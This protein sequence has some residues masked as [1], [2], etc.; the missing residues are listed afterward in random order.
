ME[1][2]PRTYLTIYLESSLRLQEKKLLLYCINPPPVSFPII[3][4]YILCFGL[5]RAIMQLHHKLELT[6]WK[7]NQEYKNKFPVF[8]INYCGAISVSPGTRHKTA[9]R[10]S[11]WKH[12][13]LVCSS[14]PMFQSRS[15]GCWFAQGNFGNGFFCIVE[16]LYCIDETWHETDTWPFHT[17]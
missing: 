16:N 2:P 14:C 6:G 15:L 11:V 13:G 3:R 4:S 5:S 7:L 1:P 12:I 17:K 9:T 10:Y 8:S